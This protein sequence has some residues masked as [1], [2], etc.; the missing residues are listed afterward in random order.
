MDGGDIK[1]SCGINALV[2][3]ESEMWTSDAD[4]TVGDNDREQLILQ[5]N[6]QLFQ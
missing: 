5:D 1:L 2:R 3:A 6:N 4:A